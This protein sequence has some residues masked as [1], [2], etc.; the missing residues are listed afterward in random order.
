MLT[1]SSFFSLQNSHTK[2][3]YKPYWLYFVAFA[4]VILGLVIY[5]WSATRT[6][7]PLYLLPSGISQE[8]YLFL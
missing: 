7:Y 2:Q 8:A 5:F 3:H 1:L 6:F 4:V